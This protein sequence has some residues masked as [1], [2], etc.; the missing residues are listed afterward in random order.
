MSWN[1]QN[2]VYVVVSMHVRN[3]N[4]QIMLF[5]QPLLCLV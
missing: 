2:T 1:G 3:F 4:K 5:S